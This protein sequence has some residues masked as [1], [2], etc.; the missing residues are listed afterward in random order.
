MHG[1]KNLNVASCA[2]GKGQILWYIELQAG[3]VG[4]I[5]YAL[6]FMKMCEINS[7]LDHNLGLNFLL[8]AK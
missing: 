6:G 3:I 4:S 1:Y 5:Q 7:G 2:A 8:G